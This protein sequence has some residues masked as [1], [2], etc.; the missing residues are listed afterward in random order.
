MGQARLRM[1]IC[2]K[3]TMEESADT[4]ALQRDRFKLYLITDDAGRSPSEITA[5]VEQALLGGVT[6]VQVR[7]KHADAQ[8]VVELLKMLRPVCR[9]NHAPLLLNG[10]LVSHVTDLVEELPP[11]ERATAVTPP[12]SQGIVGSLIDGIHLGVAS[13]HAIRAGM[14]WGYSAHTISEILEVTARGAQFV[15]LSPVFATPSKKGILEPVGL[16]AIRRARE[17]APQQVVLAL[18]GITAE[19]AGSC[20]ESGADGVAVIRAI[21]NSAS[22]AT[23]AAR[24]REAIGS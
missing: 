7:E 14:P 6:A 3:S 24:L 11:E 8:S 21:M 13:T 16:N 18:G 23:A 12:I 1:Y 17:A 2:L 9:A 19:N 10:D 5:I 20:I 22:P 15:T 4:P